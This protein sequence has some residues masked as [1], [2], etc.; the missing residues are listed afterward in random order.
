[1][2]TQDW[3]ERFDK[4][5]GEFY[6]EGLSGDFTHT[7]FKKFFELELAEAKQEAYA[8]VVE[9]L[10]GEWALTIAY[11]RNGEAAGEAS[12]LVEFEAAMQRKLIDLLKSKFL[13]PSK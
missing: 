7:D 13:T 2:K 5:F 11:V 8:E 4:R 12:E 6:V 10:E 3:K 1:M 9:E